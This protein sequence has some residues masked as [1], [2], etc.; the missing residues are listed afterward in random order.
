MEDLQTV[1][2]TLRQTKTGEECLRAAYGIL[3]AKYHGERLKTITRLPDLFRRNID[4]L[5]RKSGFLHCTN[6]NLLLKE[7]LVRSGH[8]SPAQIRFRWTSSWFLV[9]HQY[10]QVTLA[11]GRCIDIDVWAAVF[12]IPYGDHSH[13]FHLRGPSA[14][15]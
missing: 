3:T 6:I 14:T 13:G 1:T 7:L 2:I 11:D 8:F 9:P 15:R 12:G 4:V 10:A 5:W